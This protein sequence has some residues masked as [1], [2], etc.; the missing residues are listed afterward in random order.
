VGTH[1]LPLHLSIAGVTFGVDSADAALRL[2][3]R[4]QEERFVVPAGPEDTGLTVRIGDLPAR[5]AGPPLF[6]PGE[7]WRLYRQ[8]DGYTLFAGVIGKQR[9]LHLDTPMRHGELLCPPDMVASDAEA[10]PVL[11]ALA[12]PVLE[13]LTYWRLA[14]DG[15]LG[16]HS[17]GVVL[18]GQGYLF[19]GWSGAGKST[20][21]DLWAAAGATIINEDR[22][23]LRPGP[24]GSIWMHGTPWHVS[25]R[26]AAPVSA[27]VR[28][29]YFIEHAPRHWVQEISLVEAMGQLLGFTFLPLFDGG[30]IA[31]AQDTALSIVSS[32]PCRRLGFLP[33]PSVVD[34]VLNA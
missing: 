4:P 13:L 25:V 15:G 28:G 32:V 16:V 9:A 2:Q 21:G 7:L 22:I 34:F 12:H 1:S 20:M 18:D 10:R 3:L 17:S 27:P 33:E 14:A 24:D 26:Y 19:S 6:S 23:G 29:I 11:E 31:R 30:Q 5:P 8:A